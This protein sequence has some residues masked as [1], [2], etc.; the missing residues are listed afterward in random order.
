[1]RENR[2]PVVKRMAL[3]LLN[4]HFKELLSYIKENKIEADQLYLDYAFSGFE[5]KENYYALIRSIVKDLVA[6]YDFHIYK[7]KHCGDYRRSDSIMKL[8]DDAFK[9][10]IGDISLIAKRTTWYEKIV[11]TYC[12][13]DDPTTV[14]DMIALLAL[15]CSRRGN[16]VATYVAEN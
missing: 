4:K 11:T 12:V 3:V 5:S 9:S 14:F 2:K 6:C 10:I 16:L 1:M 8:A 7:C 13:E 15:H